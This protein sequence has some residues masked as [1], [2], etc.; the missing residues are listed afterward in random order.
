VVRPC[1]SLRAWFED[2]DLAGTHRIKEKERKGKEKR[3]KRERRRLLS[4]ACTHWLVAWCPALYELGLATRCCFIFLFNQ[5]SF[6]F[7]VLVF[8]K[9]I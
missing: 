5:I 3:M 8:G 1:A 9:L 4:W 6:L 7:T 2:D